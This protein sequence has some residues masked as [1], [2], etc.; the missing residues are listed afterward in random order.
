MSLPNFSALILSC[1]RNGHIL[2]RLKSI[3]MPTLPQQ[4]RALESESILQSHL[5]FPSVKGL[6]GIQLGSA[7]ST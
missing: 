6:S 2:Y 4:G 7:G 3:I 5:L 1:S